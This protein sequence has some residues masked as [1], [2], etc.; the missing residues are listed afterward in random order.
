MASGNCEVKV[1]KLLI[2]NTYMMAKVLHYATTLLVSHNSRYI[3][4]TILT[5]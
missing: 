2:A 3:A 5:S 1:L 4:L